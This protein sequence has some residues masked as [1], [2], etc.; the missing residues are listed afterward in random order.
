MGKTYE[1]W[2]DWY[3]DQNNGDVT[4][5]CSEA[6]GMMIMAFPELRRV[7]GFVSYDFE[8]IFARA[9]QHW[10]CETPDGTIVDPTRSQFPVTHSELVY[11]EY[12]IEKHGPEPIGKCMW[13]GS[14]VYKATQVEGMCSQECYDLIENDMKAE[15]DSWERKHDATA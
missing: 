2:I 10:W 14:Y 7:R 13:C 5:Q 6:S 3:V 9:I 11:D 15:R 8:G 4:Y 1:E 12:T